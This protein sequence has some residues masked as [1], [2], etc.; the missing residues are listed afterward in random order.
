MT[1]SHPDRLNPRQRHEA[2]TRMG[3]ETFDVLVIGGGVTGAGTALDA[4]TR[5]LSVALVEARDWASGTSSRSSKLIHGG[6]RYLEQFNF[7]L[8]LEALRERSLLTRRLAPHLVRPVPFLFPL[9]HR[10]WERAY[11]GAGVAIYDLMGATTSGGRALPRHRHLSRAGAM[12]VAPGLRRDALVGAIQYYDGQVDDARHTMTLVRT[13]AR[14]GAAV[15]NSARVLSLLRDHGRVVGARVRDQESGAEIDVRAKAVVAATG[16]WSDDVAEMLGGEPGSERL[17]V[18]AS[19]GV[20][21]VVPKDRIDLE[22]GLILRTEKSVLFVIPW[23][24]HW[25]V[26]TTDTDWDLDRAHPAASSR[27]IDYILGHVN[28]V[29]RRP[30]TADDVEGVYAG[31]RPLLAGESDET[32]HLSREHAVV[33]PAAGLV[34]VA[35][36]KYTTY[37]VMAADAVDA[38]ARELGRR[39]PPSRTESVPLLGAE[40][41]DEA[42]GQREPMAVSVGVPVE[43]IDHL[44]G[45][46]GALTRELLDL[47]C[48]D[49]ALGHPLEGAPDYLAAEAVYAARDEGALHLDDILTRRTRIS[50]ETWSRGAESA[51]PVARLVAPLLRWSETDIAREVEH[52]VLRVDAERESQDMPDDH[53]ADAAR[54][55]APDVRTGQRHESAGAATA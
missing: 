31:L 13:A 10:G 45:R 39:V 21:L 50:V 42:V 11:V 48:A 32:S 54:L 52:Y 55:G 20:H 18:R 38:A 6:L 17:R 1:S 22:T 34:V 51:L 35:G 12:A 37:R 33:R 29:L 28:R 3:T 25:I 41:Y 44:L 53:T 27:D 8:V 36:G 2:L 46:Y 15:A 23:G 49:R 7:R 26:G 14:Y 5:N 40:G 4:V 43:T 47:I 19:K 30:L 9:T 24:T 16:V